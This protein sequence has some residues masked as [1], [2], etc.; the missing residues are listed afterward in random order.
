MKA[1]VRCLKR[2]REAGILVPEVYYADKDTRTFFMEKINGISVK[3]FLLKNTEHGEE[4]NS[5]KVVGK[6]GKLVADLHNAKMIH[7]DL[8]TSNMMLPDGPD[9]PVVAIDFGLGSSGANDETKSVDLYVLERAF[10]STHPDSE[11]LFGE[12]LRAYAK[13]SKSWKTVQP[14]LEKVRMRGRKRTAFG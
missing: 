14:R 5:L 4:A 8:T 7:G 12:V 11:K 3:E 13:H 10:L 2:C 9:G 1:E 6:V